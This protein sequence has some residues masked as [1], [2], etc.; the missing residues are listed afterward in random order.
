[1]AT[2]TY[3]PAQVIT[4]LVTT[5]PKN[6]KGASH[7]RFQGYMGKPTVAAALAAGASHAD[8]VWDVK[9]GF[10]TIA[11]LPA[12]PAAQPAAPAPAAKPA[13]PF[14]KPAGKAKPAAKGKGKQAPQPSK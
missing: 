2:S 8:L 13:T 11:P 9:H 10:Y 6:P 14:T 3:Q 12:Q 5:N 1:M 7:A 4:W